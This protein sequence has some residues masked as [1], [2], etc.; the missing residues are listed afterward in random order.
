[1][2]RDLEK[3]PH[4]WVWALPEIT[5]VNPAPDVP[6]GNITKLS[7]AWVRWGREHGYKW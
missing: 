1:M 4:L 6:A 3:E 5:G 2:L 7:E